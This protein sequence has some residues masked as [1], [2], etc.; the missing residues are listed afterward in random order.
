MTNLTIPHPGSRANK[1]LARAVDQALELLNED[2]QRAASTFLTDAGA[3]F[4]TI[5][6]VLAEPGR[7]RPLDL[8]PSQS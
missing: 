1:E 2:G 7:R 5:V 8:P 6:R 4:S 3:S